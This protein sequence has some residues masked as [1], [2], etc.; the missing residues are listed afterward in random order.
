[1]KNGE[2][3]MEYGELIMILDTH[4][5]RNTHNGFFRVKKEKKSLSLPL[6]HTHTLFSF[7][8]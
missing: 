8:H 7:P 1:M 6:S 3:S 5:T 4:P 2:W